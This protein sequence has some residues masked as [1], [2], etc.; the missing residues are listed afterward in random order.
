[1]SPN[2]DSPAVREEIK[3]SR[4]LAIEGELED[5]LQYYLTVASETKA[6]ATGSKTNTK[7]Q[8]YNKKFVKATAEAKRAIMALQRLQQLTKKD[9]HDSTTATN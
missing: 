5:Q 2:I 6:L 9:G 8:F 3:N 7:R 4:L 1:M